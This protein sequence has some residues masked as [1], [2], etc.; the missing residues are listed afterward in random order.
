[1][2][3][4]QFS[5]PNNDQPVG[6]DPMVPGGSQVIPSASYPTRLWLAWNVM[7]RTT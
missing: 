5:D 7:R 1:V 4:L 3:I 6:V 2:V